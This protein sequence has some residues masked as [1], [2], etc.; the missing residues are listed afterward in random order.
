MSKFSGFLSIHNDVGRKNGLKRK[1]R[2]L[3]RDPS[4][5]FRDSK[6]YRFWLGLGSFAVVLIL[7]LIVVIY[8][9]FIASPRYA[10]QTQFVVKQS[11]ANE[12]PLSGFAS[13]ATVSPTTKDALIIKRFIESKEMA[14]V[15]D[16]A[17]SL[18]AHYQELQWDWFSRL[19]KS[20]KL[21]EYV[22]YYQ[23]HIQVQ[24]D[25]MSDVLEIEVQAFTPEYTLKVANAVLD[26][27]EEFINGLGNKMVTEQVAFAQMEVERKY[28]DFKRQQHELLKFQDDKQLFSP[29]EESGALLEAINQ[30]QGEV[31]KAEARYKELANVMRRTAPEV[32]A[33]KNLVDSLKAQLIEERERLISE[34]DFSLNQINSDFQEIKLNTQLA[35][36]LY[37]SSLVSMETVRAEAYRKLKHLLVVEKPAL[38]EDESYP[39]RFYNIVTWFLLILI[40]YLITRLVVAIVKEHKE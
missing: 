39:R 5:F 33:Q 7:S 26:I 15:L 35:S 25:E 1:A 12:L 34:N 10:T 20:A 17:V 14:L 28:E 6:P 32:K 9:G 31:I 40:G 30:L 8:F 29:E 36:D 3:K 16:N 37:A 22:E 11:G 24:H 2:K 38:P 21:E 19:N 23:N 4:A 13:F 27:S 18:R